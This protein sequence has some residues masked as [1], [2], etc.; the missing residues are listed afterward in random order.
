MRKQERL[1]EPADLKN[2]KAKWT[3]AWIANHAAKKAW[4]WPKK[5]G[6]EVNKIILLTLREQTLQHCSFCDGFPV[7]SISVETIEHFYPKSSFHDKAF[8]W[9]NLFYCCTRCQAAKKEA[10][11]PMLLKPDEADYEFARYFICDFTTGKICPNPTASPSDQKR[12][13]TTIDLYQLNGP[14]RPEHRKR[15]LR[16]WQNDTDAVEVDDFPYRDFLA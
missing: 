3:E 7:P 11:D 16:L 2:G 8:E 12:A 9:G 6:Q 10:F 4:R 5:G 14:S 15:T 13:I 1:E